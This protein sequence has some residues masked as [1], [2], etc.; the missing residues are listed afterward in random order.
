MLIIIDDITSN[1]ELITEKLVGLFHD[2]GVKFYPYVQENR[3]VLHFFHRP[4]YEEATKSKLL[5]IWSVWRVP[6][7]ETF[8]EIFP[9][10]KITQTESDSGSG[11]DCFLSF[12]INKETN[13]LQINGVL[14]K[15]I[16]EFDCNTVIK[17]YNGGVSDTLKTKLKFGYSVLRN[18]EL[19]HE[20]E[21]KKI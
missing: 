16:L 10:Q 2:L 1:F 15:Y 4:F 8:V 12:D 3:F 21:M 19:I 11:G 13:K 7:G 17:I 9:V 6:V 5:G 20:I 14:D 18:K